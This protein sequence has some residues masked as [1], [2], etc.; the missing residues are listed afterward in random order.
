S[1]AMQSKARHRNHSA[2]ISARRPRSFRS[3]RIA[4]ALPDFNRLMCR[5][6]MSLAIR[7]GVGRSL[8]ERAGEH[9]ADFRGRN[10]LHHSLMTRVDKKDLD[11]AVDI[12]PPGFAR[13]L[14]SA[15]RAHEQQ[16]VAVKSLRHELP[17]EVVA[18]SQSFRDR[19]V[20]MVLKPS[21]QMSLEAQSVQYISY[22]S[23]SGAGEVRHQAI[24]QIGLLARITVEDGKECDL[25][26]EGPKLS[27]NS[28][29]NKTPEGPSEQIVR[30][31]GLN[32]TYAVDIVG[33]HFLD[34]L[35]KFLSLD[36]AARLQAIDR[37]ARR[38]MAN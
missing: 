5:D 31:N 21:Q 1:K 11:L 26:T 24:Q 6:R 12:R 3:R 17:H 23:F 14:D 38:N 2:R 27:R 30:S 32:L 29:C 13:R 20:V 18:L 10:G 4:G 22:R 33:S 35:G 7:I 15:V 34:R 19:V 28:E 8:G 16:D 25:L 37:V 9:A 36:E